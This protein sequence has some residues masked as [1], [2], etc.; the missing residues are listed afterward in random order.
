[1]YSRFIFFVFVCCFSFNAF[2]Q[3][4]ND[5]KKQFDPETNKLA[6]R[7]SPVNADRVLRYKPE[8]DDF[9]IVN[10]RNKFNRALYG[11]NTGFRLE[12]GDVPEFAL[13]LPNMGG[14]LHFFISNKKTKK[15]L[16]DAVEIVCRYRAGS[17]I[18]EIKDPMLGNGSLVITALALSQSDGFILSVKTVN[19]ASN[20]QLSWFLVVICTF[21]FQIKK[22]RSH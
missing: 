7:I 18:Y 4:E 17:R 14:N 9:V 13:Y 11:S 19:I 20:I 12:T 10:G 8:G 5:G 3:Y 16:N 1:M 22:R 6:Q 15:P 2:S 21:L